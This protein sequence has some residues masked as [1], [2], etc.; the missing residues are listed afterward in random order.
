MGI[1]LC[2]FTFNKSSS[3]RQPPFFRTRLHLHQAFLSL[4]MT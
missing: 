4:W 2:H 3:I 1:H